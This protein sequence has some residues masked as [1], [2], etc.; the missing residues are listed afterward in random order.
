MKGVRT[1][2]FGHPLR[3][4]SPVTQNCTNLVLSIPPLHLPNPANVPGDLRQQLG[5]SSLPRTRSNVRESLSV[6]TS[7]E[8]R[9]PKGFVLYDRAL[10]PI[11]YLGDEHLH[12]M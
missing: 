12:I 4:K 5:W 11:H 10:F 2:I 7:E 3:K 8:L 1:V 6:V 9:S